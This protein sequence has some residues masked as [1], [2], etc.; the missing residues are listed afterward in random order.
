MTGPTGQ[1]N[2]WPPNAAASGAAADSDWVAP[3]SAPH[4]LGQAPFWRAPEGIQ[5]I[6]VVTL[7][8]ACGPLIAGVVVFGWRALF[9]VGLSILSCGMIERLYYGVT[10]TPAL[11]GRSHAYL[12]GLLLGLT[13]PAF[14]P[15][16]VPVLAAAFAVILGK[17]VFGG[18]GHFL[19]QP[20]LVGRLAV[21]VLLPATL[22]PEY[23]PVLERSKMVVGDLLVSRRVEGYRS[24]RDPGVVVPYGIDAVLLQPPQH[25]LRRLAERHQAWLVHFAH[26]PGP[27]LA[28]M[29]N[30]QLPRPRYSG[31]VNRPADVPRAPPAVL[32]DLPPIHEMFLGARPGGIGETST[33]LI[34]VSGLYLVYRNFVKWQLPGAMLLAAG[35]V[36]AVAPVPL[37]G[38][39]Q[40]VRHVWLPFRAE[41]FDVGTVYVAYQLVS[42]ELLLAAF[43][44]ATE[45]T[46]RP[47]STGGQAIFATGCGALGMLLHLYATIPV[48]FYAAVLIMNTFVPAIDAVWRPRALGRKLFW[49]WRR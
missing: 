18:V 25:R 17:A 22:N 2:T 28:G 39:G 49:R 5:T 48:P 46:T 35:V 8:A 12:T 30:D 13:L 26:A 29:K 15:W 37:A 24:W 33:I 23:W 40:A 27:T 3:A 11:L 47:V 31:L 36:A 6:F 21:A 42:G 9:V 20:A 43:F 4:T 14:V 32:R 10:R 45:M 34:L 19:W 7:L 1:D 41:G 44:L 38:A 16:Y